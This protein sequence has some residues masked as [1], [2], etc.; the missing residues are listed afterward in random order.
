MLT[1]ITAP[2]SRQID[3]CDH[4]Y[5]SQVRSHFMLE[6]GHAYLNN[7]AIGMPP[8]PV[9]DAVAEGFRLMSENPS[10][11]KRIFHDYIEDELR[12]SLA[13]FLGVQAG[14]IALARNATEGLY[15][16]INGLD[17]SSGDQILMTTQE[18]PSAVRPWRVRAERDGI[19]I[20]EVYIPSPLVSE[21]D[22]VERIS[23]AI[24]ERTRVLFF[25]HVTRGGYLY[26]VKRLSA[27]ARERG[28]ISA[29]DGAQAVGMLDVDVAGIE[30]DLYTN[31][32]HKWFLGPAGTGFLYVS[33]A[34]QPSFTSLYAPADDPGDDARRFETQGTYDLPVRAA[35]GTALD[36]LNRI[37]ICNIEQRLRMLSDYLRQALLDVP[38]LRLLT[39]R[40][41][42]I[43]SPGSTIFEFDG[44]NAARWRGPLEAESFLHVD[45]HDRDGHQGLRI[46]THYYVTTDEIDRCV[47]KLREMVR[48]E[49]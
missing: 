47:D 46:S 23:A 38:R 35:L 14:E 27:L 21:D 49:G 36:F 40:A 28:L 31:S 7:A 34:M 11:A 25:C 45:D 4:A 1:S 39:S 26:P 3:P 30:C 15:H 8:K 10:R 43:S 18:H 20:K 41:H 12:P 9:G 13:A 29:I 33:H 24:G 17:L 42:D 5:W 16:L 48:R 44:I 19:E 2:Q 6:K 37:G 22:V 32:L